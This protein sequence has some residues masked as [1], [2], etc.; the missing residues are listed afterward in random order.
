MFDRIQQPPLEAVQWT[1]DNL[2]DIQEFG[3]DCHVVR[4]PGDSEYVLMLWC[5]TNGAQGF[6]PVPIGH[7]VAKA[8]ATPLQATHFYP[9]DPDHFSTHFT[10][11]KDG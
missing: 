8:T 11:V 9:I 4:N 5:G 3:A 7:W 1:G 6:V 10:P 2:I